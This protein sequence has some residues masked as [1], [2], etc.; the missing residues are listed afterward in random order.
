MESMWAT[1]TG[2]D[3]RIGYGSRVLADEHR[4]STM[5]SVHL[6]DGSMINVDLGDVVDRAI[7]DQ[8]D[9]A[10]IDSAAGSVQA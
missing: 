9:A 1:Y 5:A 8:P 2:H 7:I 3:E 10:P 4:G 6:D